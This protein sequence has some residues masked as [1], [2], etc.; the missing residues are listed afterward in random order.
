MPASC[1][2]PEWLYQNQDQN[3][4]SRNYMQN[5]K[6]CLEWRALGAVSFGGQT[7]MQMWGNAKYT[8]RC[9]AAARLHP[10]GV[11]WN[12]M[13]PTIC[14]L[15]RFILGK[16]VSL[17]YGCTQLIAWGTHSEICYLGQ[18]VHVSVPLLLQ[19][20]VKFL[21]T[22][23]R[24]GITPDIMLSCVCFTLPRCCSTTQNYCCF[25]FPFN[26]TFSL[27]RT[28]RSNMVIVLC[29]SDRSTVT[30]TGPLLLMTLPGSHLG[31]LP[32]FRAKK[33]SPTV[34]EHS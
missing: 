10:W 4:W 13:V 22:S 1:R 28:P 3:W 11:A 16:N 20:R 12:I 7:W 31:P 6:E 29:P 34:K 17:N 19:V 8:R 27:C 9:P 24:I 33:L 5:T 15:C 30:E 23:R 21:L 2:D 14:R 26:C 18:Q 32:N 25:V